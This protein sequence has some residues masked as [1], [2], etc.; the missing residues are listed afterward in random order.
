MKWHRTSTPTGRAKAYLEA[1]R[2]YERL[3]KEREEREKKTKN[4]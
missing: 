4:E 3:L 2:N 1:R